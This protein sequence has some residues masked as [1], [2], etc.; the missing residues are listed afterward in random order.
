MSNTPFDSL[1]Y[2]ERLQDAGVPAPQAAVHAKTL[3]EVLSRSVVFPNDLV[4]LESSLVHK[5]ETAQL[6]FES[7]QLKLTAEFEKLRSDTN[8]LKAMVGFQ[9]SLILPILFKLYF[10]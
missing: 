9:I 1:A 4:R 5:F 7:S 6:K 3:G 2:S 10:A 8:V